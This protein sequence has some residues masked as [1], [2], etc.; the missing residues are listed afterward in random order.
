MHCTNSHNFTQSP[1]LPL[2]GTTLKGHGWIH[3]ICIM[4][5]IYQVSKGQS[6]HESSPESRFYTDPCTP[7]RLA[8]RYPNLA[9]SCSLYHVPIAV[10]PFSAFHFCIPF[11]L[12]VSSVYSCP[13]GFA[14]GTDWLKWEND[15]EPVYYY[16]TSILQR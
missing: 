7:T 13:H 1:N 15:S 4:V 12:F 5:V 6:V 16:T 14:T 9:S 11:P 8:A 2:H 10:F 3:G